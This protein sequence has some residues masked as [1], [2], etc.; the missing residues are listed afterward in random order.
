MKEIYKGWTIHGDKEMGYYAN[1][2]DNSTSLGPR[3]RS[4][5]TYQSL[6]VLKKNIDNGKYKFK[7]LF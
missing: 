5:K 6:K 2:I 4:G 1:K 7:P 3:W